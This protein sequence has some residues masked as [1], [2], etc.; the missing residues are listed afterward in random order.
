MG[1]LGF[2]LQVVV[3]L[4]GIVFGAVLVV[5]PH[6]WIQACRNYGPD[7]ARTSPLFDPS[8]PSWGRVMG[9]I[10]IV[11]SALVLWGLAYAS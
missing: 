7:W 4:C 3:A 1:D 10:F 11:L 5:A 8:A 6:R 2:S 9:V